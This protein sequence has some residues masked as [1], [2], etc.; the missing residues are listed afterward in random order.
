M[1]PEISKSVKIKSFEKVRLMILLKSS[2]SDLSFV[3]FVRFNKDSSL[4]LS[5]DEVSSVRIIKFVNPLSVPCSSQL[6]V[7]GSFGNNLRLGSL[8]PGQ[9]RCRSFRR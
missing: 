3:Q 4:Q 7:I 6:L 8:T 5:L 1:S 9:C 2:D